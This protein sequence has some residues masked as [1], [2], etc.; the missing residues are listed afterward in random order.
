MMVTM[1]MM[2]TM[3]KAQTKDQMTLQFE[4]VINEHRFNLVISDNEQNNIQCY[5][6]LYDVVITSMVL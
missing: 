1:M 2:N 6:N 5:N 3:T 4:W